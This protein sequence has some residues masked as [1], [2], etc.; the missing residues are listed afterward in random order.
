MQDASWP[1]FLMA[2][3]LIGGTLCHTLH[4]LLHDLT[5]FAG[6]PDITV[7]KF[8]AILCN[9][10]SLFPS[11][12]PFGKHHADHH[13]FLGEEGKDPDL[14]LKAES[15]MSKRKGYKMFFW[16][17]MVL[18]YAIRPVVFSKN[19]KPTRD[20]IIN[21]LVILCTDL[22]ILKMWGLNAI[23]FM[24]ISSFVS[25]GPHPAA[26]H[27]IAE[28]YEIVTGQE[29][30]DYFGPWNFFNLNLGYH[31]EHHDFPNC[32]WYNLPKVRAAAPEFYEQLPYHTSYIA[33]IGKFLFDNNFNLF[34]RILRINKQA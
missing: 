5:H 4:V 2:S 14:P 25:M 30:Y 1:V 10:P 33:L 22:V 16:F 17:F 3:Y 7:N 26:A 32:P 27:V 31:I 23:L 34:N 28:H 18:F 6:H 19:A 9:V 20:E 12:L 8:F 15:D 21:F 11:A 13:N 24:F 29:T